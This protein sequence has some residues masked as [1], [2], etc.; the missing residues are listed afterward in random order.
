MKSS[1][2][3]VLALGSLAFVAIVASASNSPATA[4]TATAQPTVTPTA[5]T[6]PAVTAPPPQWQAKPY[7]VTAPEPQPAPNGAYTN[8]DGN[9]VSRPYQAPSAP[10]GASARCRDGSYSFS[11][12]RQGTCSH[13]GGVS[14][15]L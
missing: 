4:P 11:Q 14:E 1:S 13:H 2:K 15:W 10:A 5:Q 9:S 6:A 8:V 3:W 7:V 12:H